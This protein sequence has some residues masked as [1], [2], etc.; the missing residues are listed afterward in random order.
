MS[1]LTEAIHA[2]HAKLQ[3]AL[4]AHVEAL[5]K[6]SADASGLLAFLK[7]ELLPHA[8]SEERHLYPA[9]DTLV[10]EHGRATATMSVDHEFIAEYA[11][12]IER[13]NDARAPGK[14]ENEAASGA[15]LRQLA[16]ELEAI[17]KLHLAKEERVYLPL[18]DRHMA[19]ADQQALLGRVHETFTEEASRAAE[20]IVDVRDMPPRERHPLIFATLERLGPGKAFILVNDHDPKPLYYQLEAEWRGRFS[21]DYLEQ[22][23]ETWRVRIGKVA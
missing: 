14:K 21:W 10:K 9:V 18:F 13:I 1:T 5:V 3:D 6:G 17:V 2:H 8:R 19:P 4:R 15:L 7:R 12:R 20:K 11:R 23:P 22:G 16:V